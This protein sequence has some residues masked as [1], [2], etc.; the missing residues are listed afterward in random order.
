MIRVGGLDMFIRVVQGSKLLF[1]FMAIMIMM[2]LA[3]KMNVGEITGLSAKLTP[4]YQGSTKE[5]KVAFACNVFWG[6]EYLPAMFDIFEAENIHI[7]FFLG[8]S[9]VNKHAELVKE[10]AAKGHELGNHSLTHPHPN[11]LT[12]QD[13]KEQITK[14]EAAI[15]N[16]TGTT[17]RLYAPPYGEFNQTV[18]QAA[19]ELGYQTIMWTVDTIDWQR[20]APEVIIARVLKKVRNDA[21]ILMHPTAPT[22]EALPALIKELKQS[23]FAIVPVSAII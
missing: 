17:T 22:A 14:T 8:G 12:K 15:Y 5:Q 21:I 9:W 10:M 4:I 6:E 19:D 13:N 20:P 7:T 18:L 2:L 23:G 1:S 3:G 11:A 16:L